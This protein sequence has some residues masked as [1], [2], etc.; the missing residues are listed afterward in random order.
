MA[1]LNVTSTATGPAGSSRIILRGNTSIDKNRNNQP[2]IVVDG[3]PIN[4]DNLGAATEYG[5]TDAGDGISS[6]NPDDIA[7]ISVL[8]GGTAAALYGSR[9]SNG[10]I[11][12]TTKG[13]A[14]RKGVGVEFSSNIVIDRPI[15]ESLDW[16]YDY[17]MGLNGLKPQTVG[18]ARAAGLFSWGAPLDG[19]SV[20]QYDGVSR[21]YSAVKNNFKKFYRSGY[22]FTNP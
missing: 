21:P 5:G 19:S 7:T 18:E 4:N 8:K 10:V 9:A 15:V 20:I 11:L 14:S 2:L 12:I 16:Q 3:I 1:G 6:I 13:G 17:G 22:T